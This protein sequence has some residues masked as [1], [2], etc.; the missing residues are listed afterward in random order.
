MNIGGISAL[1]NHILI[2]YLHGKVG[3]KT[4]MPALV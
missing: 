2:D 1:F 4:K 3:F